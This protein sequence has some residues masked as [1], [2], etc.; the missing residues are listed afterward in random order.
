MRLLRIHDDDSFTLTEDI[1]SEEKIP[2]YAILSHTWGTDDQEVTFND[3]LTGAGSHKSGYEK[4]LFC[5]KQARQDGLRHCWIDTCCINKANDAELSE[6]INSM[7]NWYKRAVKCYVYLP[8]V[9]AN[10]AQEE[11]ED[12]SSS[13]QPL[14]RSTWKKQVRKS[15]WLY[16]GWTLQELIAPS[17]VEFFDS[18]HSRLG[19]KQSLETLVHEIT[20][21]PVAA[22]RGEPLSRFT[23]DERLSWATAYS[24]FGIFGIY[25]PYSMA[26][27]SVFDSHMDEHH[28]MC[29]RNTRVQILRDIFDWINDQDAKSVFWLSGMAGTG[30]SR[31]AR[32]VA[33]TA[34][35]SSLLSASFFFKRGDRDRSETSR[36]FSTIAS[37]LVKRSP[38]MVTRLKD[39]LEKNPGIC[40]KQLSM[41]FEKLILQP[42]SQLDDQGS[43]KAILIIVEALD[44]CDSET[45]IKNIIGLFSSK[46]M[47]TE[48]FPR[49]RILLTSRPDIPVR[50]GF[51]RTRNCYE[52]LVLHQIPEILVRQDLS[53]YLNHELAVIRSEYNSTVSCARGL[54]I[55]WP[56]ERDVQCLVDMASPLFIFAATVCRFIGDRKYGNPDKNLQKVLHNTTA[57]QESTLDATYLPVLDIM[58]LGLSKLN[59]FHAVLN[60]PTQQTAPIT[61]LHLSF[62]DFLTD[63]EKCNSHEFWVDEKAIHLMIAKNCLR[64][65]NGTLHEN[66]GEA[67]WPTT[68]F[69]DFNFQTVNLK[70]QPEIR[71]ACEYWA[72]HWEKAGARVGNYDQVH[73]FLIHHFFYWVEALALGYRL[74]KAE[75][76]LLLTTPQIKYMSSCVLRLNSFKNTG[77]QYKTLHCTYT[78]V[79][80]VLEATVSGLE[81]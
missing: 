62:R 66:M 38:P 21:I 71:Y 4:I 43:A 61:L 26:K 39:V 72:Y 79:P 6:A 49:L 34:A 28:R 3:L 18:N 27:G 68:P 48:G 47:M 56:S 77:M 1:T 24:L 37:Q 65:M 22:L 32:T 81:G 40:E 46:H 5:C 19:S 33:H 45:D 67:E 20:G 13:D 75:D 64:I 57:H 41:Q 35:G 30:K 52:N 25:M 9:T 73:N 50:L 2:Q 78:I 74:S 69:R 58:L 70:L 16:R 44:E 17:Q 14:R 59:M 42:I 12:P 7:F 63:V 8:D 23:V 10:A 76:I 29:Q 53:A 31:I 60:V 15:R 11:C 51:G 54:P 36:F 55:H 80:I